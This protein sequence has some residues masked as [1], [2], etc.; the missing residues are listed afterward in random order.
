MFDVQIILEI[1]F[2]V[3]L[4]LCDTKPFVIS[5]MILL[6]PRDKAEIIPYLENLG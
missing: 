1:I 3:E 6:F 2:L 4:Y 5:G